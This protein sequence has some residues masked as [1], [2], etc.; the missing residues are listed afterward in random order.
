MKRVSL[1]LNFQPMQYV[2]I[3]MVQ[4]QLQLVAKVCHINII[5]VVYSFLVVF[6]I[7]DVTEK[8][9]VLFDLC[10]LPQKQLNLNFS[11]N[12]V[13]WN[14]KDGTSNRQSIFTI[15]FISLL[16]VLSL[17]NQL[18]SAPTNASVVLWDLNKRTKSKLSENEDRQ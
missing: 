3:K 17:E 16:N 11:S 13:Q 12:H 1:V 8:L 14:P 6:T 5:F 15:L 2:L 9:K 18:A 7:I 10:N 4:K